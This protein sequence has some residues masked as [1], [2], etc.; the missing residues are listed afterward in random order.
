[1]K[2]VATTV[3]YD[4]IPRVVT[5][6]VSG[7]EDEDAQYIMKPDVWA[8]IEPEY[9]EQWDCIIEYRQRSAT[10]IE[11]DSVKKVI[12]DWHEKTIEANLGDPDVSGVDFGD[13]HIEIDGYFDASTSS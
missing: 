10:Q 2:V 12:Q 9:A 5:V 7:H 6:E 4:G 8:R 3:L 1:M 13:E 11:I